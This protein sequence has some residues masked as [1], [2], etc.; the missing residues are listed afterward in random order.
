MT[1]HLHLPHHLPHPHIAEQVAAVFEHALHR[2]RHDGPA[3]RAVP[4]ADDW[5]EWSW[6]REGR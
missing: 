4:P 2:G 6:D 5:P 1:A 3:P